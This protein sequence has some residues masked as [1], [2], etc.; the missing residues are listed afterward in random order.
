MLNDEAI[1]SA[2]N[3]EMQFQK[4]LGS[5][6]KKRKVHLLEQRHLDFLLGLKFEI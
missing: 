1:R 5:D 6:L 3:E 4:L 2:V